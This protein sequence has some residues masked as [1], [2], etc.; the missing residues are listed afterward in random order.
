MGSNTR[1]TWSSHSLLWEPCTAQQSGS[2]SL[3]KISKMHSRFALHDF[4]CHL[5]II[6]YTLQTVEHRLQ[7]VCYTT[8][9]AAVNGSSICRAK[10][11]LHITRLYCQYNKWTVGMKAYWVQPPGHRLNDPGLNAWQRQELLLLI[12]LSRLVMGLSKSNGGGGALTLKVQQPGHEFYWSPPSNVKVK[13]TGSIL[14]LPLYYFM[15]CTGTTLPL[16]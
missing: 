8:P 4:C 1:C 11:S 10:C 9:C 14:L 7:L 2:E 12:M 6:H 5:H 16:L 3:N 13:D 15:V